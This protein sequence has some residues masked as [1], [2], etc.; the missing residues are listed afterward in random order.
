MTDAILAQRVLMA[1]AGL[2]LLFLAGL[3][4][5][6]GFFAVMWVVDRYRRVDTDD[7]HD[8]GPDAL[9]L[10]RDVDDHLDCHALFA[11]DLAD[12]F[13]PGAVKPA[14]ELLEEK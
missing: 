3:L 7:A 9:L 11:P 8:V 13:G 10:L 14:A 4:I 6:A 5:S 2:A 1:G 12:V